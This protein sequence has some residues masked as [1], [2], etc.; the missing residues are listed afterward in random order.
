MCSSD[1]EVAT[2]RASTIDVFSAE[3]ADAPERQ[4]VSG[5]DTS[6]DTIPIV[7]LVK[8]HDSSDR[9]E[10]YLPVRPN[11]SSGWVNASDVTLMVVP[12]RIEVAITE[13]R[14]RVY[15]G[16]AVIVDEP[17]GVGTSDRPTPGGVY[18]AERSEE[19]R[20][21]KECRSRWSPYH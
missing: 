18:Y 7:F 13:H 21:G 20:V 10:V 2:A 6:V 19:R 14:L 15:N 11:G 4:I 1:L 9:I 17:V 8:S 5:V 3:D 12:Y 16:D